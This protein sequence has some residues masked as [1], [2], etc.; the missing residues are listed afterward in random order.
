[1]VKWQPDP[2]VF[3]AHGFPCPSGSSV[4]KF[5]PSQ[6]RN[7]AA[8]SAADS[9]PAPGLSPAA[10]RR[11]VIGAMT[12]IAVFAF[13][14]GL[15]LPLI[16]LI[17]DRDGWDA[18]TVGL[19][20]A[21]YAI[22]MVAISP[23]AP[24]LVRVVGAARLMGLCLAVI[25]L[26]VSL[27]PVFPDIVVW[28][29]LRFALGVA[30]SILFIV[31]EAWINEVAEERTRGRVVGI[32]TGVLSAG[33][34]AGP[35]VIPLTGIDGY[36]PF[37]VAAIVVATASVPL[38][39]A[40]RTA[41][42]FDAQRPMPILH[43][44]KSV[45]HLLM[46][47]VVLGVVFGAC[48]ALL[49]VYAVH[50]GR[51]TAVAALMLSALVVGNTVLQIPLGRFADRF[52]RETLF[53]LCGVGTLAGCLLLPLLIHTTVV[54]WPVLFVWGGAML[55]LFTLAMILL[56]ERFSG[57]DLVLGGALFGIGYG[58]GGVIGPA[59]GGAA[60]DLWGP[61]GLPLMMVA[62]SALFVTAALA[63]RRGVVRRG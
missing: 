50:E 2:L 56:G 43:F 34:G 53:T 6:L 32:Y 42:R 55:G 52:D 14:I 25:T 13:T 18:T 40:A 61:V 22:A 9:V 46:A 45:P 30:A 12:C 54:L 31:G 8:R 47:L 15:T 60:M 7:A 41:P 17:L 29:V 11:G 49:P 58:V 10:R 24:W 21:T 23:V 1:M 33:Y 57:S 59:L 4:S 44:V 20:A 16:S 19:N 36:A 28:F 5:P 26:S 39:W 63:R 62:A 35:L 37:V 27:F 3:G 38:M 48:E 51:S